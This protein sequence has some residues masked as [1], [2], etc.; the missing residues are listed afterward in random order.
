[1]IHDPRLYE[2]VYFW[3]DNVAIN[4]PRVYGVICSILPGPGNKP[5]WVKVLAGG[6]EHL[7][8]VNGVFRPGRERVPRTN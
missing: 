1:M 2:R 4:R 6:K 7:R 8:R 3:S 5:G